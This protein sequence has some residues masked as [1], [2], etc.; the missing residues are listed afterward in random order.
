M[1][2]IQD[3]WN[4]LGLF[5]FV[6]F[7]VDDYQDVNVFGVAHDA[8]DDVASGCRSNSRMKRGRGQKNVGPGTGR[9]KT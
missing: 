3:G 6:F 9:G 5:G 1:T 8:G 2:Y 7:A 4:P